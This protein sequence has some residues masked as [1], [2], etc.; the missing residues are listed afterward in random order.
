MRL[1]FLS[2]LALV[3]FCGLGA[4]APLA[5]HLHSSLSSPQAVGVSINLTARP[6]N[7]SKG[8]MV[9][10]YSVSVNGGPS[11][12]VRDFSQDRD[13]TWAPELLEHNA[14]VRVTVRNNESK[15]T[16]EDEMAFQLVSRIKG[17]APVVTP[18]AHPLMT[19]SA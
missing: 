8:M 19:S 7:V 11:R 14:K 13:F 6:E 12:I 18:S 2:S 10:R 17:N 16:A 3:G 5:V 15:E 9:F 1:P 4:A